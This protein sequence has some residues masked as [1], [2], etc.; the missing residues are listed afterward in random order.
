VVRS[1]DEGEN[2]DYLGVPIGNCPHSAQ[3]LSL[4]ASSPW[5]PTPIC[6]LSKIGGFLCP[7]AALIVSPSRYQP[8]PARIP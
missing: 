4:L 3:L 7:P 2:E 5:L 1:L 8:R 6:P